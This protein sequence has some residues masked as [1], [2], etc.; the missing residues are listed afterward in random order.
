M[1]RFSPVPEPAAQEEAIAPEMI[2]T[3]EIAE[4][5]FESRNE[6]AHIKRHQVTLDSLNNEVFQKALKLLEGWDVRVSFH[7]DPILVED[8]ASGKMLKDT[9][10][11]ANKILSSKSHIE[12]VN[13][14]NRTRVKL[15]NGQLFS[16]EPVEKTTSE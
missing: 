13:T 11:I 4:L 16:L 12:F 14:N 1:E 10:I 2:M 8:M 5:L 3:Q 15:F 9:E 7:G 6:R